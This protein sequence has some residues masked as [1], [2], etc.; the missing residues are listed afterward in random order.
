MTR[1]HHRGVILIV[2]RCA[3][4]VDEVNLR[5]QQYPPE[6]GRSR[7][8]AARR[9]YVPIVR[10]G[11]ICVAQ[12]EDVFGFKVGVDEVE[13]VEER[14]GSKQLAGKG[15]DVGSWER[16][17]ATLFE[18]VK[19]RQAEQRCDNAYMASPVEAVTQLNTS[20]T[21]VLVRFTKRLQDSK[22]DAASIAV[23]HR[24]SVV[25]HS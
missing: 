22:L 12:Q 23:L 13:V 20:I 16:H 15:L 21:I 8:Q 1:A 25:G 11:L 6:L 10:E 9:R 24:V 4:K 17:E 5:A 2:K 3:A 18:E 7:S 14:D 19:D